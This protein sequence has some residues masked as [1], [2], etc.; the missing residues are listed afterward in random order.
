MV[1]TIGTIVTDRGMGRITHDSDT[2]EIRVMYADGGHAIVNA[3]TK[4]AY[5]AQKVISHMWG[6]RY[7]KHDAWVL[8]LRPRRALKIS[9]SEE[10]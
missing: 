2:A 1:R 3:S 10:A 4:S 7:A 9:G 8:C 5:E 6:N